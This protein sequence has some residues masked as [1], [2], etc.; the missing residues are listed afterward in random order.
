MP[1]F[2]DRECIITAAPHPAFDVYPPS[3]RG[4]DPAS[5]AD[6]RDGPTQ[7]AG[8]S[9]VVR[10]VP[11]RWRSSAARVRAANRSQGIVYGSN[12]CPS[13]EPGLF[14]R[15]A[16]LMT[17]QVHQVGSVGAVKN[18]FRTPWEI[19]CNDLLEGLPRI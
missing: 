3:R 19:L 2:M 5:E 14:L 4:D 7:S 11:C 8:R 1:S 13:S 16:Q 6:H 12:R 15:E 10:H 17:H 18:P 9:A